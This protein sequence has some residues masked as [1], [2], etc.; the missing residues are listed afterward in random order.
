MRL[1]F[2]PG[3]GVAI[4]FAGDGPQPDTLMFRG[5]AFNRA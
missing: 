5:A 1:E 3:L 2:F 4:Q